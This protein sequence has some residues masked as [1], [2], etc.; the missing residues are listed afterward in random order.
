M[1]SSEGLGE[2]SQGVEGGLATRLQPYW[3]SAGVTPVL[4]LKALDP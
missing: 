1:K 2:N 3:C 4:L